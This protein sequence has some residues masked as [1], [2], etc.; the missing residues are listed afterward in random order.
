MEK[1]K[2]VK[3][4]P[5]TETK[6]DIKPSI[7][8]KP[9]IKIDDGIIHNGETYLYKPDTE[10][11]CGCLSGDKDLCVFLFKCGISSAV[12]GF[13]MVML[14]NDN[15]DG[16]YIST[17]SLILGGVMGSNTTTEKKNDNNNNN[18]N[19]NKKKN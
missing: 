5:K 15:K 13:C 14:M 11:N 3:R 6:I 17:I 12:L 10:W 18:N 4:L 9:I 19:N 1:N 8:L 16:F 2:I 7:E